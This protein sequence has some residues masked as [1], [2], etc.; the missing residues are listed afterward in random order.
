M[1]TKED[2]MRAWDP[3][4]RML[5][6]YRV[7]ASLDDAAHAYDHSSEEIHPQLGIPIEVC[8]ICGSTNSS[9]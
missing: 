2:V 9:H 3:S 6:M 5:R 1:L 7:R 8:G 4:G